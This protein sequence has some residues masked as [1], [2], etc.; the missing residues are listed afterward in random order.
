MGEHY[1]HLLQSLPEKA[2]PLYIR[3]ATKEQIF[4]R[5]IDTLNCGLNLLY[6][7]SNHLAFETSGRVF[8][9]LDWNTCIPLQVRP[10][11][12]DIAISSSTMYTDTL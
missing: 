5:R 2:Y 1:I 9:V 4:F 7:F 8:I 6:N 3:K 10:V 11:H 12:T